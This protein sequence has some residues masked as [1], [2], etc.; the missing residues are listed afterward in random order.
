[1]NRTAR[2]LFPL[3]IAAAALL[4]ACNYP[5][6]TDPIPIPAACS[7]DELT[8]P[9]LAA[10]VEN[11]VVGALPVFSWTYPLYCDPDRV[12]IQIC[13][14]PSCTYVA[15]SGVVE[16]PGSSWTP[17]AP[18]EDA[19]H[20]YWR[21]AAVAL[22]DGEEAFGPWSRTVSFFTGPFCEVSSPLPPVPMLP[23]NGAD[24][25]PAETLMTL[26][27]LL[28]WS[29]RVDCLPPAYHIEISLD[30]AFG[31]ET[32]SHTTTSPA[33]FWRV[34]RDLEP[35]Q[36]YYWRVAET[37]GVSIGPWSP[38][39]SFNTYPLPTEEIAVIAGV[40][41]HDRCAI[42]WEG[43]PP[44][45]GCI[46]GD[47]YPIGDGIRTRD[48]PG[49]PGVTLSYISGECPIG[50]PLGRSH[51][52]HSP[53]G[54]D[55]YYYQWLSPGTYCFTILRSAG[56]NLS[57]FNGGYWT[58]PQWGS[59]FSIF[60]MA[61]ITV[62]ANEARND[63]DFGFDFLFGSSATP[64]S[65]TGRVWS[66]HDADGRIDPLEAGL[67]DVEVWLTLGACRADYR[68]PPHL[69]T[70]TAVDGLYRFDYLDPGRYCLV[71]DPDQHPNYDVLYNGEWTAPSSGGSDAQFVDVILAE[72]EVRADADFGW[73]YFL[74]G[75]RTPTAIY[76]EPTRAGATLTVATP[77]P[78]YQLWQPTLIWI[79][80]PTFYAM[81]TSTP[82][83]YQ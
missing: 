48:E 28:Q 7:S 16:R 14:D 17:D 35:E 78:T 42:D 29:R 44:G 62:A 13:S 24:V 66:D 67:W 49:I 69:T 31:G 19:M 5:I 40:V 57:I 8:A 75:Y 45:E 36:T 11:E 30:P 60:P 18:L 21:A 74:S 80:Q 20:F 38:V 58:A 34:D 6:P 51:D 12:A 59:A 37:D 54:A 47:P 53:T 70:N 73:H 81:P 65:I 83:E 61:E 43:G 22:V 82:R 23:A 39:W 71:V 41:W 46:E 4:A 56:D 76:F 33:T 1:M 27:P 79:P 50:W 77:Q 68:T 26:P 15:A 64:G 32:I 3:A 25:D 55:G 52:V 9:V 72:G 63:V 2:L 10:P